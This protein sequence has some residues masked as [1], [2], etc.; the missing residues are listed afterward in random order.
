M[1]QQQKAV[2]LR[3]RR[4]SD[5]VVMKHHQGEGDGNGCHASTSVILPHGGR[6]V[7]PRVSVLVVEAAGA[8]EGEFLSNVQ[9][10]IWKALL[11]RLCVVFIQ[12]VCPTE[13][14]IVVNGF[15]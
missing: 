6:S 1:S 9:N 5:V 13:H 4:N 3:Y 11:Q 8:V 2:L 10:G 15:I 12:N 7:P 14:L